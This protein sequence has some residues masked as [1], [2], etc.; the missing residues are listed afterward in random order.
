MMINTIPAW[1]KTV[2]KITIGIIIIGWLLFR[3]NPKDII[4]ALAGVQISLL[5]VAVLVY[6]I[7]LLLLSL[8]WRFILRQMSYHVPV[9]VT[10]QGFVAGILMSDMTPARVGEISRP[11]TIR[12]RVPTHAG[13]GSVFLDRYC[14][15]VAI[16]ILGCG[17]L[18]LLSAAHSP[19]LL[20]M[21]TAFL[22]IP[23]ILLTAFWVKRSAVLNLVHI[24]RMPRLSSFATDLGEAMDALSHPALTMGSSILFTLFIWTLQSLRLVL[25][26]LAAGF[27]IPIQ[28]LI[29]IQPLISALALIPFSISGLGFVEGGYVAV[30]AQYGVPAAAGLAIALLDR[31]LTVGFHLVVGFRYALRTVGK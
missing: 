20:L 26:A 27:V 23:I 2:L 21:V 17:G 16:F 5:I 14:D 22:S 24:F 29:F 1:L 3:F 19:G 13:L 15:F 18:L 7:T 30:F 12:D 25:I 10:Y 4:D 8:R 28:E 6:A 31:V 9:L 11:L